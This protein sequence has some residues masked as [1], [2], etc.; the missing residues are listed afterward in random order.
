MFMS[1]GPSGRAVYGV[2]L[3]PL[4]C[5]DYGFE[6]HRAHG[7][8]SWV[9]CVCCLCDKL[10]THPEESYRLW[11][12]VVCD[13]ETSKWGGPGPL[14]GCCPKNKPTVTLSKQVTYAN[15]SGERKPLTQMP[16]EP[17]CKYRQTRLRPHVSPHA[18]RVSVAVPSVISRPPTIYELRFTDALNSDF[19]TPY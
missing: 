3:R 7:C 5:W 16:T 12:V 19:K 1:A 2:G 15:R 18:A 13:L 10:I 4:I 8:L 11:C 6:S 14:G 17:S 9:F